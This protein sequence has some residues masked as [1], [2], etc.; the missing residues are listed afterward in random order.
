[1]T[2][3]SNAWEDCGFSETSKKGLI[4]LS[5]RELIEMVQKMESLDH[6]RLDAKREEIMTKFKAGEISLTK[7]TAAMK[8]PD[9]VEL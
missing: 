5:Q 2:L 8:E 1:M 4:D 6:T 3:L 7:A 9:E